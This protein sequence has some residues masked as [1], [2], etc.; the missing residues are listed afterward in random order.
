MTP[1]EEQAVQV[2]TNSLIDKIA[3]LERA[4]AVFSMFIVQRGL[5]GEFD[6]FCNEANAGK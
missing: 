1:L 5:R 6:E 4:Q 3:S 2:M